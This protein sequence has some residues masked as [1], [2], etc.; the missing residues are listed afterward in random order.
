M[1]ASCNW[2][3]RA[4]NSNDAAGLESCMHAAYAP[5]KSRMR[6]LLLPPLES[7]YDSEIREYPTWV[8]ESDGKDGKD[9]KIVGGLIM[10]FDTHY[11]TLSNIAVDPTFQGQGLGRGLMAYAETKAREKK[12]S[13]ICLATHVLLTENQSLYNHLGWKKTG[14]DETRI[15]FEKELA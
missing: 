9:G 13:R 15:Y 7:D 8:A 2:R 5:Y 1:S 3:I 4:A 12:C 11:A 14:S 10:D 6:G